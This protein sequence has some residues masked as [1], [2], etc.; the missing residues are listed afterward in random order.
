LDSSTDDH[1]PS[2]NPADDLGGLFKNNDKSSKHVGTEGSADGGVDQGMLSHGDDVDDDADDEGHPLSADGGVDQGML[3]HRDDVDDEGHQLSK[4]ELDCK[5]K[6]ERNMAK[7]HSLGLGLPKPVAKSAGKVSRG[8]KRRSRGANQDAIRRRKQPKREPPKTSPAVLPP[9]SGGNNKGAMDSAPS[10]VGD[11][12]HDDVMVAGS[13]ETEKSEERE[14]IDEDDNEANWRVVRIDGSRLK[15]GVKEYY[16]KWTGSKD[17][18]P[19]WENA[20]TIIRYNGDDSVIKEYE[21]R[22]KTAKR[23]K[24]ILYHVYVTSCNWSWY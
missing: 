17:N 19:T 4:Y 5:R 15:K 9:Q 8:N 12:E 23:K 6:R 2:W 14:E 7:L 16:C 1:D 20:E 13:N 11:E 10:I 3:S 21:K 24:V 22:E 18:Y